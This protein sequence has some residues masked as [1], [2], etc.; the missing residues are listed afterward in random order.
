VL[1]K[2]ELMDNGERNALLA[3]GT[4][5]SAPGGGRTHTRA[6]MHVQWHRD[7]PAAA[8]PRPPHSR[9]ID[10]LRNCHNVVGPTVH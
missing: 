7:L 10:S 2:A 4:A 6:C 1:A 3:K 5:V 8:P 9:C